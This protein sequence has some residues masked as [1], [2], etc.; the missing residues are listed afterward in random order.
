MLEVIN[1]RESLY[2]R[3]VFRDGVDV[4]G[5]LLLLTVGLSQIRYFKR[6]L[7]NFTKFTKFLNLPI[8]IFVIFVIIVLVVI[9]ARPLLRLSSISQRPVIDMLRPNHP[10]SEIESANIVNGPIFHLVADLI[11]NQLSSWGE[12][13]STT[14]LIKVGLVIFRLESSNREI[15]HLKLNTTESLTAR[16]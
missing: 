9:L 2:L 7:R 15:S 4:D 12:E 16:R 13:F 1:K 5:R 11:G 3:S 8:T 14:D 6:F 10:P